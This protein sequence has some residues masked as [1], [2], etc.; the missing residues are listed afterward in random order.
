M[1]TKQLVID[2]KK[3]LETPEGASTLLTRLSGVTLD[4][5]REVMST[6]PGHVAYE[7][8]LGA[9]CSGAI[10]ES[11]KELVYTKESIAKTVAFLGSAPMAIQIEFRTLYIT[12]INTLMEK[13]VEDLPAVVRTDRKLEEPISLPDMNEKANGRVFVADADISRY[14]ETIMTDEKGGATSLVVALKPSPAVMS[15]AGDTL[16]TNIL[17]LSAK[18]QDKRTKLFIEGFDNHDITRAPMSVVASSVLSSQLFGG[19]EDGEFYDRVKGQQFFAAVTTGVIALA[20]ITT[21]TK[22]LD[23]NFVTMAKDFFS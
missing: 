21:I 18:E 6:V 23:E 3:M 2:A 9:M 8:V 14:M 1:G 11:G 13:A 4:I 22:I 12:I 15:E 19:Y 7:S 20:A 10:G 5:V 17:L 16:N